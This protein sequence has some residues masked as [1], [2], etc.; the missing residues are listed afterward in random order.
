[1]HENYHEQKRNIESIIQII[2]LSICI[3][4]Y[5]LIVTGHSHRNLELFM[6]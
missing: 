1:M 2:S 3:F 4:Y 5:I 6:E